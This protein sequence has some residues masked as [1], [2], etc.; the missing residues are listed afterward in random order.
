[1]ESKQAHNLT[2]SERTKKIRRKLYIFFSCFIISSFI[3][4][5]IQLSEDFSEVQ[6]CSLVYTNIPSGKVL[7]GERDT[8]LS[9]NLNSKGFRMLSKS[10]HPN[11]ISISVDVSSVLHKQ[12]NSSNAFFILTSEI[13]QSVASQLN[14][15]N[16][17]V[18][19]SPDTLSFYLIDEYCKKLP[20]QTM[21]EISYAQQYGLSDSLLIIP[22][23]VIVKGP[24]EV[25]DSL[26][27][28]TTVSR[29]LE[30]V[31]SNQVVTMKFDDSRNN[32]ISVSP[33]TVSVYVPVDKFTESKIE[34][35]I[36]VK[37]AEQNLKVK[38]FPDKV[39]VTFLVPLNKY[40]D[41]D[42]GMFA[43]TVDL[44]KIKTTTAKKL[45]VEVSKIPSYIKLRKIEP[46]KTEYII[47][48]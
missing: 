6:T 21:L 43:A 12:R 25:V 30:N 15:Q 29:V 18:S 40:K 28:I 45:K 47:L 27:Y 35:P 19:I 22:D 24:K 4:L 10:L 46:E 31:S 44:S 23:S 32:L 3:W 42:P 41:I 11:P 9:V 37:G 38:T 36:I 7:V 16:H 5:I 1:M 13:I 26:R 8:L 39:T 20:V 14:Q 33:K 48:K 34:L 17:V 2:A